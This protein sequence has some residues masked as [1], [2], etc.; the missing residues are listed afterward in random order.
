[1]ETNSAGVTG[2]FVEL[3]VADYKLARIRAPLAGLAAG[4]LLASSL[5]MGL[6]VSAAAATP[7][8]LIDLIHVENGTREI[9]DGGDFTALVIGNQAFGVLYGSP[10]HPLAAV[11][12][13]TLFGRS[14][15]TAT[16]RDADSN[17]VLN[18]SV[19]VPGATLIAERMDAAFEF[20]DI[21][22][23]GI[24]NF[25]PNVGTRDPFDFS[26]SEPL[27]KSVDLAGDWNLT[28]FEMVAVNESQVN[29][30]FVVSRDNIP[31]QLPFDQPGMGGQM[32]DQIQFTIHVV[33]TRERVENAQVPHFAAT[34]RRTDGVR[35]LVSIERDG[36]ATA[37]YWSTRAL[38]KVDHNIT[39]WDFAPPREL[40]ESKL[41]LHTTIVYANAVDRHLAPWLNDLALTN[42]RGAEANVTDEHTDV[43]VNETRPLAEFRQAVAVGLRDALGR[44]GSFGWVP[45]ASVWANESSDQPTTERVRFQILGGAPF[46]AKREN[47]TLEG[48]VL[49]GGFVYPAG[50]RIYH[51]PQIEAQG[52]EIDGNSALAQL[53]P[54]LVLMGETVVVVAAL[55]VVLLV[56]GN[57]SSKAAR[58]RAANDAQRLEQLKAR[59]KLPDPA[60]PASKGGN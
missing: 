39:G 6:P 33:I 50:Y 40:V 5:L 60:P 14:L 4:L 23:D 3:L 44:A 19:T 43:T 37:S 35:E 31:Y 41:L 27:V 55:A 58:E 17:R 24:F 22:G 30:T 52:I 13:F 49:S 28:G 45:T 59:Y 12:I 7:Q 36:N 21:N 47:G 32:L 10:A 25:R 48:F 54:G 53:L 20:R 56:V 57:A 18:R 42:G 38:F 34:V 29:A 11:T 46:M 16:V 8:P 2:N 9:L 15:G 51:D 1:M 26:A